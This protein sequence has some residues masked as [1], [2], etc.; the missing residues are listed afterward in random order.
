MRASTFY[1][2]QPITVLPCLFRFVIDFLLAIFKVF[3]TGLT[4]F[5]VVNWNDTNDLIANSLFRGSVSQSGLRT[6][7]IRLHSPEPLSLYLPMSLRP[8]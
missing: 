3:G 7:V 6:I 5:V 1:V 4:A 2:I 8:S